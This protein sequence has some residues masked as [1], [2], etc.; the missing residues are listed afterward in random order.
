MAYYL[1]FDEG[2]EII[3]PL[4]NKDQIIDQLQYAVAFTLY[5]T[6]RE[7]KEALEDYY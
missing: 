6:K 5:D 1:V 2:N 7:A 4:K 3:G